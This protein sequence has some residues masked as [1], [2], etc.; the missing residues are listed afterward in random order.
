MNFSKH[1]ASPSTAAVH[2][3]EEMS[4]L[5]FTKRA[6]PAQLD[7]HN[8]Q[9]HTGT[10]TRRPSLLS[11]AI[12]SPNMD[13]E[14]AHTSRG[15]SPGMPNTP[16]CHTPGILKHSQATESQTH[17]GQRQ[18]GSCV[19]AHFLEPVKPSRKERTTASRTK[20]A[21]VSPARRL[22]D[23]HADRL[24]LAQLSNKPQRS[25]SY[26]PFTALRSQDELFTAPVFA[27]DDELSELECSA[28]HP[29]DA[30]DEQRTPAQWNDRDEDEE[31][32]SVGDEQDEVGDDSEEYSSED[33]DDCLQQASTDLQPRGLRSVDL[34]DSKRNSTYVRSNTQLLSEEASL[35]HLCKRRA[36][37]FGDVLPEP[38]SSNPLPLRRTLSF[39]PSPLESNHVN[40]PRNSRLRRQ[41]RRRM[42]ASPM[43]SSSS[44][45]ITDLFDAQ[46]AYSPYGS[47]HTERSTIGDPHGFATSQSV[48]NNDAMTNLQAAVLRSPHLIKSR[49]PS[50]K[51]QAA[52]SKPQ[53]LASS[54]DAD[55]ND[56]EVLYS[57]SQDDA[58][59]DTDMSGSNSSDTQDP[60]LSRERNVRAKYTTIA[61]TALDSDGDDDDDDDDVI[62]TQIRA[63]ELSPSTSDADSTMHNDRNR[64]KRS[65]ASKL[66]P[67]PN[68]NNHTGD[69][70]GYH[71]QSTCYSCK[72]RQTRP[73]RSRRSSVLHSLLQTEPGMSV[74]EPKVDQLDR[75][76]ELAIAAELL[77]LHKPSESS[78]D[79]RRST[80]PSH[81]A[82]SDDDSQDSETASL[83]RSER[84]RC[85]S[86]EPVLCNECSLSQS[87]QALSPSTLSF[88][89]EREQ[90]AIRAESVSKSAHFSTT[91]SLA[92]LHEAPRSRSFK[93]HS[94]RISTHTNPPTTA[95]LT[96][97]PNDAVTAQSAPS[98]YE[99]RSKSVPS[100]VK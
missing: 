22:S 90:H 94:R 72:T 41:C 49:A 40:Y 99:T 81:S 100:N 33:D 96:K 50:P 54:T 63:L 42:I 19:R 46:L 69:L 59:L 51:P 3:N 20:S 71:Q 30:F 7:L 82:Q 87:S 6:I 15:T 27:D 53:S 73:R 18:L 91:Q 5:D 93:P 74:P 13:A 36:L 56:D 44:S 43:V 4:P 86:A 2:C 85:G 84:E 37:S 89:R 16:H 39:A 1:V 11:D 77:L 31:N 24:P 60:I 26:S 52:S 9:S 75:T 10:S 64:S 17:S 97:C 68:Y 92:M 45:L 25:Q 38:E 58:S 12:R 76:D 23:Q 79:S 21:P 28:Y 65:E 88:R 66:L 61:N 95:Q 83:R 80:L 34:K 98:A 62:S 47:H 48:E 78:L 32:S 14:F 35:S 70:A 55:D 8:T 57:E 29:Q 67:S